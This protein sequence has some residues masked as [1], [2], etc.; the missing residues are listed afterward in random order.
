[1]TIGEL[2]DKLAA[3]DIAMANL[4]NAV[5]AAEAA[6]D[7][8][9]RS[10]EMARVEEREFIARGHVQRLRNEELDPL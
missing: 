9:V 3:L 2:A 7:M 10:S 5:R 8:E 1:M 4:R 6:R